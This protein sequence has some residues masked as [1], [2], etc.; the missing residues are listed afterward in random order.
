MQPL[1]T[2]RGVGVLLLRDWKS[3]LALIFYEDSPVGPYN[4]YS[5]LQWQNGGP[6]VTEMCVDSPASREAGRALWGFPKELADLEWQS[7]GSHITFRRESEYFRFRA[8]G[9]ALPFRLKVWTNQ[10]LD[11]RRVRVPLEVSGHVGLA[12]RG[13]QWALVLEE[14]EMQVFAPQPTMD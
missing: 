2:L 4:E 14:F 9:F 8:C 5:V 6:S 13:R 11:G 10:I 7:G 1:W 12:F 3:L